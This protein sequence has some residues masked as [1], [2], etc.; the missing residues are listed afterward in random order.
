MHWGSVLRSSDDFG[1]DVDDGETRQR[2]LP[3]GHGAVAQAHLA[4]RP[5]RDDEPERDVLRRRAGGAVRVA[6]RGSD[7]VARPRPLRPPAPRRA[8]SRAA[9]ACA[10]TPC[11]PHPARPEADAR[12]HLH[13]RRLPHRRRRHDLAHRAPGRARASSSPTSTP[14][15]ASACTRWCATATGRTAVP[16]EP[17]G[18]LPQRRRGRQ[19]EGRRQRRALR[20]R[21]RHGHPS[22]RAGHRLH[23]APGV[24]RVPLHARGPAARL[25]HARR[26]RAPG[27]R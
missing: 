1:E 24:R 18:P 25:P 22:A 11:C 19:L 7:L 8:G 21:L 10:C 14:S 12:R 3:R 9:A 26:R 16:A 15:S 17:L 5:G 20:L 13:R 2:A 6:R 23:R 27:S 4:D